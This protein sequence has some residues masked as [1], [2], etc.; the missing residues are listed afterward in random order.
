MSTRRATDAERKAAL[1][2]AVLQE[3][4]A[5]GR[6]ET[7]SEYYAVIRYG[8]PVNT[9]LHAIVTV[10]TGGIWGLFWLGQVIDNRKNH[11]TFT[12]TADEAGNVVRR[13]V[14]NSR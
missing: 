2:Q 13:Q 3:V 1:T 7:Q 10:L 8:K 9:P 14:A 6:V 11:K 5:G 4:M 12:L